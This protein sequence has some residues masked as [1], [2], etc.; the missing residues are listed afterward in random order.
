MPLHDTSYQHWDGAYIGLWHRRWVIAAN[1]VRACLQNKWLRSL[2]LLCWT[3]GLVMAALLFLVGQ[4]LVADSIVVDWIGVLSANSNSNYQLFAKT[5]TTWLEQHPEVSVRTTQDILFYYYGICLLPMS[6]FAL[7]MAMP[8]F[9]TR[10]LASN[11]IIIYAS[12]AVSRGDYLLGKFATAFGVLTLTWLGPLCAAWFVGNLLAPDWQFF[13]HSR[14]ALGHALLFALSSMV[15]LSLL[16][17]GVSATSPKEK[18]TVAFWFIWWIVG[19]VVTPI[20]TFT[21][22]WL[23]HLNFSFDLRQVALAIFKLGDDVKLAQDKVPILG[24]MLRIRPETMA[25]INSPPV[26]GALLALLLMVGL[27][28]FVIRRRVKPE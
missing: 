18:S 24:A 2:V 16:A 17:L 14:V 23:R 25:A 20:A 5:F 1:G 22:P 19:G 27:A 15:I 13:W 6:V 4:L 10:D 3:A 28:V 8:L 26:W 21:Q 7:G 9:I 11:A 12:K